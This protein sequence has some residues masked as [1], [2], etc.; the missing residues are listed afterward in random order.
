LHQFC[1][2]PLH[3]IFKGKGSDESTE[4]HSVHDDKQWTENGA[5]GNTTGGV[6]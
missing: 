5:L 4:R 3:I 1:E 6:Y 2:K